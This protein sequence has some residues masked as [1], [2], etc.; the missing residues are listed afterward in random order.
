MSLA[1][2]GGPEVGTKM[3]GGSGTA[4]IKPMLDLAVTTI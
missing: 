4:E 3:L 1:G 2:I